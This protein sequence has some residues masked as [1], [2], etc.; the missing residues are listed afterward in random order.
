VARV[1]AASQQ[2]AHQLLIVEGDRVQE[3]SL[4]AAGQQQINDV[5]VTFGRRFGECRLVR[6]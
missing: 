5:L 3:P 6:P 4:G 1:G 2:L